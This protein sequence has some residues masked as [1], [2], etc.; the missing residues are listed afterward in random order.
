VPLLPTA[1]WSMN[2]VADT[3]G[4]SRRLCILAMNKNICRGAAPGAHVQVAQND[5]QTGR[6][7][8]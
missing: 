1:R 5:N 2:F 6:L 8:T 3:F 4:A 7:S